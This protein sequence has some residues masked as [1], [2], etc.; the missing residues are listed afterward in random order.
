MIFQPLIR[1]EKS[2]D[3]KMIYNYLTHRLSNSE[4]GRSEAWLSRRPVKPEIAGSIPVA[5][6]IIVNFTRL[7]RAIAQFGSA[8]GSGP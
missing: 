6:E 5:P 2:L 7:N 4:R 1:A 8:H 3:K